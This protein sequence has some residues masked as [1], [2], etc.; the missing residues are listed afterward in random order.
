MV[1]ETLNILHRLHD[2]GYFKLR[3]SN[4]KSVLL[5][6]FYKLEISDQI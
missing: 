1:H 4:V 2:T 6:S 3:F 5:L